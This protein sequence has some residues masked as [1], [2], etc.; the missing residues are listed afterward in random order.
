MTKSELM[1]KIQALAFAKTEAE[2]YLDCHPDNAAAIEYYHKINE[3]LNSYILEYSNKFGPIRAE[4]SS[5]SEWNWVEDAWPWHV[6]F[7]EEDS[8]NVDL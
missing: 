8:D 2:L 3:E 5:R 7:E 4:D 1:R 6:N